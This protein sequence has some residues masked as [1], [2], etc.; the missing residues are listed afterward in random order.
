MDTAEQDKLE[1]K[2]APAVVDYMFL[3]VPGHTCH[4]WAAVV[5]KPD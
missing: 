5:W 1:L 3:D 2:L 4:R